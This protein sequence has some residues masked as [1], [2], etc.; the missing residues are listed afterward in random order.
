MKGSLSFSEL[1][2]ICM[3]PDFPDFTG[4]NCTN[5]NAMV[6]VLFGE[7]WI[8]PLCNAYNRAGEKEQPLHD[9]PDA[10]NTAEE[11]TVVAAAY[12][13]ERI[14]ARL[15]TETK[16][17]ILAEALGG[18]LLHLSSLLR[19]SVREIEDRL[20]GDEFQTFKKLVFETQK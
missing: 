12:T 19:K 13:L 4:A 17:T 7:P 20:D 1:E 9:R 16:T 15:P 2:K 14:W 18:V 10:G 8:C 6:N 3:K 5:C 11:I